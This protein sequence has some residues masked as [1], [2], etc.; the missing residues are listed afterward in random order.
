MVPHMATAIT[1]KDHYQKE[2]HK[3]E[4]DLVDRLKIKVEQ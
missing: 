2:M 3:I 4:P 1:D